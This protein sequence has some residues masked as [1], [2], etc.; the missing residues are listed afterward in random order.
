V[1]RKREGR[2][3]EHL[4][5]PTVIA[6]LEAVL[7]AEVERQG[8]RLIVVRDTVDVPFTADPVGLEQVLT[9]LIVNAAQAT[10]KGGAV[11][12]RLVGSSH[13][14][15][16]IVEDDGPGIP[17]D[18]LGRIFEPFYTTKAEGE[19]TGLGLSVSLGIVEQAGGTIRAENRRASEGGGA[20]F[21]V[22]LP[23]AATPSEGVAAVEAPAE[24]VPAF[25]ITTPES[26]RL[27]EATAP[28]APSTPAAVHQV[29]IVDDEDVIRLALR[30]YFQ[31]RNWVVVEAANGD[32]G[33]D[34]LRK[35]EV[36]PDVI[37]SDLRMP[38]AGGIELHAFLEDERPDLL[39]R[40]IISTGDV[41]SPDA[42]AFLERAKCTVLEKPFDL[43]KLGQTVDDILAATASR[44][45]A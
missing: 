1:V 33:L 36:V 25:K 13:F 11:T 5:W 42:A 19:G 29:L 39:P 10:G 37:V 43:S 38:G 9:N 16:L 34:I 40:L 32:L 12:V 27:T 17:A 23:R 44:V 2:P 24:V 30:R 35:G 31:R 20:R 8:G 21:T 4:T 3:A 22:T 7:R 41:A 28:V 45:A 18:V 14:S 15:Q 26:A 6:R